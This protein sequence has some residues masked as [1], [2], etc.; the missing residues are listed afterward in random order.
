M[1]VW[2]RFRLVATVFG[3]NRR[4]DPASDRAELRYLATGVVG[5]GAY[6]AL[7]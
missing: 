1:E 5:N 4:A 6:R 7:G 3:Q 2:L